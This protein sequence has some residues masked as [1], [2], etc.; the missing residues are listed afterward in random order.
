MDTVLRIDFHQEMD[1][2]GHD[3]EFKNLSSRFADD[4]VNNV[5]KSDINAMNE[6]R[7]SILR[8][9]DNVILAR[10]GDVVIRF[11]GDSEF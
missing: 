9:P 1:M 11:V 3:F 5:L 10:V 4:L 6:D 2:I 7:A 8:A